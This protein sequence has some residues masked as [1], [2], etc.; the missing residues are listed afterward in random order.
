M[1]DEVMKHISWEINNSKKKRI[2]NLITT[3]VALNLIH[4][5]YCSTNM[6]P[7]SDDHL[8]CVKKVKKI[9]QP[10]N[11]TRFYQLIKLYKRTHHHRIHDSNFYFIGHH[12]YLLRRFKFPFLR[13]VIKFLEIRKWA[14][15]N[16]FKERESKTLNFHCKLYY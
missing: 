2:S 12:E 13:C 3:L 15:D 14:G 9:F 8:V 7:Y 11:S 4:S 10:K 16:F 5:L 1:H 6:H